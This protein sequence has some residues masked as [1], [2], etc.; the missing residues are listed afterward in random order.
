MTGTSDVLT[1]AQR[2]AVVRWK[3]GHHVFHLMLATM[4]TRFGEATR[5]L[6]AGEWN[7]AR[8]TLTDLARLYDAA[9]ATMRYTADF[10]R[11][12]YEVLVR[13]SMMPPFASPGFSGVHNTEHAVMLAGLRRLRRLFQERQHAVPEAVGTAWQELLAAQRRNRDNHMF[14]CRR[15]VDGGTSLLSEYYRSRREGTAA[16]SSGPA[17][18]GL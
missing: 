2:A 12:E 5:A 11:D 6:L 13:P 15:F 14:V 18:T 16:P 9:S 7:S 10:P 1:P 17:A 4:N 3:L 8:T